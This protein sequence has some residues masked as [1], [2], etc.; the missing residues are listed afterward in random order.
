M[1]ADAAVANLANEGMGF[2]GLLHHGS[3]QAGVVRQFS[4]EDG[5]TEI[6]VAQ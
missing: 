3:Q 4:L 1:R 2:I 5:F 6:H